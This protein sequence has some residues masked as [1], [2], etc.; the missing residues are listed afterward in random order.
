MRRPWFSLEPCDES[1]FDAAPV[2]HSLALD[3]AAPAEAV[4]AELTGEAPLS[5]CRAVTD[6]TWTSPRPFEVGTTRTARGLRGALVLRERF[7]RWEEGRRKSFYVLEASVPP[8]RRLAED[9][10]VEETSP[11]RCR[12][13]WTIAFEPTTAGRLAAPLNALLVRSLFRDTR[14]HFASRSSPARTSADLFDGARHA[15]P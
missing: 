4:W 9:Y 11:G 3:I 7:F 5:W 8:L 13:E 6:I 1:F 2:R 15:R 10:L 12:F 14:R